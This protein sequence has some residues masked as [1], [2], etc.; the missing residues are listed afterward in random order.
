MKAENVKRTLLAALGAL[1]LSGVG[2]ANAATEY[3]V[4]KGYT[5]LT[6]PSGATVQ[7]W[8]TL[9]GT[10]DTVTGDVVIKAAGARPGDPLCAGIYV[11]NFAW[12]ATMSN[13]G[14]GVPGT[15]HPINTD[16]NGSGLPAV[17]VPNT[18]DSCYGT[19]NADVTYPTTTAAG[20]PTR[21]FI[22]PNPA[23]N[24]GNCTIETVDTTGLELK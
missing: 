5:L 1:A 2:V 8:T 19:I 23:P 22:D 11:G 13:T 16:A 14:S 7:C 6:A 4:Y 12:T 20:L 24:F 18:G 21:V 9:A 10:I 17:F 3:V 15:L